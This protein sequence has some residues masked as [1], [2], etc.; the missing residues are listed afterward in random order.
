[1]IELAWVAYVAFSHNLRQVEPHETAL[2][3]RSEDSNAALGTTF[4]FR[5]DHM[6]HV[7]FPRRRN[8]LS[9]KSFIPLRPHL[10]CDSS[11]EPSAG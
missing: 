1:M 8:F 7:P 2:E 9:I 11:F 5:V 4:G 10:C 3:E 6:L